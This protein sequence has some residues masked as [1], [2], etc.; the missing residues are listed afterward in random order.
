VLGL[1]YA[2]AATYLLMLALPLWTVRSHHP[3]IRIRPWFV[4]KD[5]VKQLFS[6]SIFTFLANISQAIRFRLDNVV[7]AMV[8]PKATALVAVAHYNIACALAM[9]GEDD[10]AIQ[11]L[12]DAMKFGFVDY[13]QMQRD[14]HH[15]RP[16]EQDMHTRGH[17]RERLP[18]GQTA[19]HGQ[20]KEA[21]QQTEIDDMPH[22]G[23]RAIAGPDA[24]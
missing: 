14:E 6:Y 3:Q 21:E 12:L 24:A 5:K 1:A 11:A 17:D 4:R 9:M 15:R 10:A 16:A 13:R 23:I 19:G 8:L 18:K 2:S 7:I 22:S 20:G